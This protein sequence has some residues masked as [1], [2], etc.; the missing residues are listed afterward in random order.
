MIFQARF[1]KDGDKAPTRPSYCHP[2]ADGVTHWLTHRMAGI[3]PLKP[4]FRSYAALPHVSGNTPDVSATIPTAHGPIRVQ[5]HRDNGHGTVTVTVHAQAPD[6]G[7]VGLRRHDEATGCALDFAT[8]TL[9]GVPATAALAEHVPGASDTLHPTVAAQHA[10]IAL[11]TS[12]GGGTYTI[13]ASF[14]ADC[15]HMLRASDSATA[16]ARMQGELLGD[17]FPVA[18]P[19]APPS[20]PASWT[21][22]TTTG[23][24]WVGKY[25]KEGYQLFAFDSNGDGATD[26]VKLPAWVNSVVN[27]KRGV[28]AF[29]G[30]D[31]K[32]T[33]FLQD[34]R[35]GPGPASLGFVTAG[36]DGSQGTVLDI[37]I[38]AGIKYRLSL[39]MVSSVQPVG[40]HTWSFTKQAIRVMDLAT[41]DPVAQDPLIANAPGGVY[42]TVTYDRG[43][44]LRVAPID[45][46]AGFSAVF[47]DKVD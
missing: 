47:F 14:S 31:A 19:Y 27:F 5:A 40:S 38:T 45:S 10:F 2:W 20:Y 28:G 11:P 13:T 30:Q 25:G 21:I 36:A 24:A 46:D 23:G 43:V 33:S 16:V 6:G 26:V 32:N 9:N 15:V 39:Y 44:R 37:N 3:V 8:A 1:M 41:L 17:G 12:V 7:V 29:V 34:P 22:D 42:W 35:P 18:P 4:G